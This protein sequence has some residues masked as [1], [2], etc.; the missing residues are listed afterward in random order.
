[1][2]SKA[3]QKYTWLKYTRRLRLV[4]HRTKCPNK[5]KTTKYY[6]KDQKCSNQITNKPKI[7]R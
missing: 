4:V 3:K 6:L 5:P 7:G 2:A 1:M